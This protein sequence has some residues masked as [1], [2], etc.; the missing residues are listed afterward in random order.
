MEIKIETKSAMM[1]LQQIHTNLDEIV[2]KGE[3][4]T[5]QKIFKKKEGK[6]C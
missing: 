4:P 3:Y 6:K 1:Y 2:K 5:K